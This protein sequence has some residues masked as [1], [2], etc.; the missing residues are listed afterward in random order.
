VGGQSQ[1]ASTSRAPLSVIPGRV[2]EARAER[3][4]N[5]CLAGRSK[6][7]KREGRQAGRK[8]RTLHAP[9]SRAL[10]SAVIPA[11]RN[12][13]AVIPEAGAKRRLSGTH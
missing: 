2:S 5:P 6:G 13:A 3:V 12:V 7:A 8:A 9:T 10:P 11:S 4:G 1:P